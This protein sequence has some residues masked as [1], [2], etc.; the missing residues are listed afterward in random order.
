MDSYKLSMRAFSCI[1]ARK[2]SCGKVMFLHLSVS[3]SVHRGRECIPA[4][5]GKRG[6]YPSMHWTGRVSAQRGVCPG[7]TPHPLDQ[8]QTPRDTTG[9]QVGSTHPTGMHCCP[10]DK[11]NVLHGHC[12]RRYRLRSQH[13]CMLLSGRWSHTLH[14]R[15]SCR[16]RLWRRNGFHRSG[17]QRKTVGSDTDTGLVSNVV[18]K[19]TSAYP[20]VS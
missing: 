20:R 3:H 2:P 11:C 12:Q 4:C 1:T 18:T 14:P 10:F 19:F 8:R 7:S 13:R 6:V 16:Y 17:E 15:E 9:Q 5:T